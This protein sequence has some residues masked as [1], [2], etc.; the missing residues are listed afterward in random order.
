MSD[1][2]THIKLAEER[3]DRTEERLD[4][5]QAV[6]DEVGQL[7]EAAE[8]AQSAVERARSGLRKARYRG[9]PHGHYPCGGGVG[10]EARASG[11]V[12]SRLVRAVGVQ[13]KVGFSKA[14]KHRLPCPAK[15]T[16]LRNRSSGRRVSP[17]TGVAIADAGGG[18]SSG[19]WMVQQPIDNML[20][21]SY[22][23]QAFL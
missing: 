18:G 8:K 11:L 13:P 3:I 7:L 14:L 21:L 4:K 19:C 1:S 17:P 16:R 23:Y 6:L 15:I 10:V 2:T 20:V 5:V 22:S 9:P 12:V